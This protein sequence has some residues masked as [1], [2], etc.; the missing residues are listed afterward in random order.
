[1]HQIYVIRISF[2]CT[3]TERVIN[4]QVRVEEEK[5]WEMLDELNLCIE[6]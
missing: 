4:K 2:S 6:F 5:V 3:G 1:M